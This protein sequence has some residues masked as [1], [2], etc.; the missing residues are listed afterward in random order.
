MIKIKTYLEKK[1]TTY[2]SV[3]TNHFIHLHLTKIKRQFT[4][5][6]TR[7]TMLTIK[8]VEQVSWILGIDVVQLQ[9]KSVQLWLGQTRC[10]KLTK[11]NHINKLDLKGYYLS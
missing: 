2:L 9:S 7:L 8:I 11:N 5:N 4:I 6:V 1:I 10:L 3:F